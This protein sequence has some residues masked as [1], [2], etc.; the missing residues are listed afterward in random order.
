MKRL[1][2]AVCGLLREFAIPHYEQIVDRL[3]G[4]LDTVFEE[5][6]RAKEQPLCLP[7]PNRVE[8]PTRNN[9]DSTDSVS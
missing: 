7:A 8:R 5:T 2:D 9:E 6:L 3:I 1:A 4:D